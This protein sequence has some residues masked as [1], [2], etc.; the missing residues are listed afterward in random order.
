MLWSDRPE[1][2]RLRRSF[3]EGR[4]V[5]RMFDKAGEP[6]GLSEGSHVSLPDTQSPS[7]PG[8]EQPVGSVGSMRTC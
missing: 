3:L 8:W 5:L 4:A 6:Q 2:E 7:V 1:R